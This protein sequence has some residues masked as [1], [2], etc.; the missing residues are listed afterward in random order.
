MPDMPP[1]FITGL[2]YTPG[3][4]DRAD[5]AARRNDW[6]EH[7]RHRP[8]LQLRLATGAIIN[9][10]TT[11]QH[12]DRI[13]REIQNELLNHRPRAGMSP[14]LD[15]GPARQ[16][17][18]T[19]EVFERLYGRTLR[20]DTHVDYAATE[21]RIA[22]EMGLILHNKASPPVKEIPVP[23]PTAWARVNG[24]GDEPV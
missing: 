12:L 20:S 6:R 5:D 23:R 10:P 21:L 1:G 8:Q 22:A 24:D 13:D 9:I 19:R 2:T 15:P 11:M 14:A 16:P 17:D 3:D 4:R 18:V 7:A